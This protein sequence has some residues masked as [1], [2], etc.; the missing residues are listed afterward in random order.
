MCSKEGNWW[1]QWLSEGL[2]GRMIELGEFVQEQDTSMAQR[3]LARLDRS[4]S[5]HQAG[6]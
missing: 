1:T 4:A 2:Q 3:Y 6:V 5:A